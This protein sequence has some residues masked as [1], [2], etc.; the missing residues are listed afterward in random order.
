ML[1]DH[2]VAAAFVV[3]VLFETDYK[4]GQQTLLSLLMVGL[5]NRQGV[6]TDE[7]MFYQFA[8]G[9]EGG[10][11]FGRLLSRLFIFKGKR[12]TCVNRG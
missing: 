11:T 8:G 10:L 9:S 12:M 1:L 4:A 5:E 7:M 3:V 2:F 6:S